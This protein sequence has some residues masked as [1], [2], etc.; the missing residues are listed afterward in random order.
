MQEKALLMKR[1]Q[2]TIKQTTIRTLTASNVEEALDTAA[3]VFGCN[4][5]YEVVDIDDIGSDTMEEAV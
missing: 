4:S 2:Y 3:D 5:D 1:Q